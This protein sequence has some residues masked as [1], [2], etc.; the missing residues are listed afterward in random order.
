MPTDSPAIVTA[1]GGTAV[2]FNGST[3][4]IRAIVA[5]IESGAE[6]QH[7][8]VHTRD[9]QTLDITLPGR[10]R[11]YGEPGDWVVRNTDGTITVQPE[12]P[13]H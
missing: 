5:W 9:L 3:S 2:R 8:A 6:Y 12:L 11:L 13:T 1:D 4:S 10:T 7:P